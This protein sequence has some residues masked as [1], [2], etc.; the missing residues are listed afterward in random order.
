MRVLFYLRYFFQLYSRIRVVM[1]D[2]A[3]ILERTLSV[4]KGRE[5]F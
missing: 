1:Q 5:T 2:E 3:K 4:R